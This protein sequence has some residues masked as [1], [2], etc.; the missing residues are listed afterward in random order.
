MIPT[1]GP[2]REV[3]YAVE[4]T[5]RFFKWPLYKRGVLMAAFKLSATQEV[6]VQIKVVDRKGNPAP[7]DGVPAWLTDNSE[8]LA[9]TPT[10]D[11][12]RCL[13]SAVG[14]LG[15]GTVSVTADADMGAGVVPIV[16]ALEFEVTGGTAVAIEIVPGTPAEQPEA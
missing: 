3:G 4:P 8:L 11:G 7:V 5:L 1:F 6:D 9:L 15:T 12:M 10:A 14:P 2:V 13:V 16:G